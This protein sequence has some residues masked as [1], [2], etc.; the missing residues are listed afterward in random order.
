MNF[1]R[2]F[3]AL[4]KREGDF[5][6]H[7]AD[8]GGATRYGITERMARRY[9]YRGDMRDLQIEMAKQIARAEYWDAVRADELPDAVRY[10]VFDGAYHSSPKQSIKWLQRA[11]GVK[12]DGDFGP[13]T[14]LA[15]RFADPHLLSRRYNHHRLRFMTDLKGWEIFGRGW[16]RRIADN[17]LGAD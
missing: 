5:S 12:D 2:A 16:A 14:M 7:P 15:L 13:K 17:L 10:D 1:D 9:G 8:P 4:L 6:D 11:A 3:E